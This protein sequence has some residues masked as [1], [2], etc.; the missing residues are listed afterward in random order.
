[1]KRPTSWRWELLA[2]CIVFYFGMLLTYRAIHLAFTHT[3]L[4]IWLPDP[5]VRWYLGE[6]V[7]GE[8]AVRLVL[9][10][11]AY[12][13]AFALGLLTWALLR[14]RDRLDG[15][16]HCFKCGYILKGLSEPRCPECGER[17]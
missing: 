1:M 14:R 10:G 16:L 12:L 17:I 11:V 4:F 2:S 7:F 13:P 8:D 15:Y 6:L 3:R 5:A 9:V